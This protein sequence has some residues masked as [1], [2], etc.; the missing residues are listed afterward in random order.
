MAI[1][2]AF[3]CALALAPASAV[4]K[5]EQQA[6]VEG[7]LAIGAIQEDVDATQVAQSSRIVQ[8]D[9]AAKK[10]KKAAQAIKVPQDLYGV[11]QG[12]APFDI[13]AKARTPLTFTSSDPTIA[14]VTPQGRVYVGDKVGTAVIT[15]K[16]E[17]TDKIRASTRKVSV[18]VSAYNPANGNMVHSGSR[19]PSY[20]R[21][22]Y[23]KWT[24]ILRCTDPEIA[25]HAAVAACF[26]AQNNRVFTYNG[27]FPTSQ[28]NVYKRA[29]IYWAIV[30][31]TG[32]NPTYEQL[33][34]IKTVKQHA[35]TSC[36]P[37]I[38]ACYWLYYD[39]DT[40]IPLKWRSP[41]N[42]KDY[43]Y[44]CGAPNVE[45]HQLEKCIRQV[46]K[47]YVSKGKLAPFEIIYVPASRRSWTF[48]GSN[49]AK[50]LKR[51]DIVA[52]C[53]NYNRNGHTVMLM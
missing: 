4:A 18:R 40:K 53:P 31:A 30:K 2:L 52:T 38:L 33:K 37:T 43:L 13:L 25:K 8:S 22:S 15:I 50:N 16:A 36:T 49:F 27:R 17:E 23:K 24:F 41:Y 47:E 26:I 42:K 5:E 51:G 9:T 35:S 10:V 39:M 48:K 29:S 20:T 32:K 7:S 46:N 28:E 34:K 12:R 19:R 3:V 11:A 44:F 14:R 45:Y 6:N 1:A 21:Y